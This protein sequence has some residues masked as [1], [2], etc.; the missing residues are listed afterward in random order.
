MDVV[1]RSLSPYSTPL[2]PFWKDGERPIKV[3]YPQLDMGTEGK[4]KGYEND[5]VIFKGD[6][7]R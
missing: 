5:V 7:G 3:V 4:G 1:V 6:G 2:P